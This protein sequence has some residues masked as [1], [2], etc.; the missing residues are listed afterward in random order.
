LR[1]WAAKIPVETL[2]V[3]HSHGKLYFAD[4]KS[5]RGP[6]VIIHAIC[7]HGKE[8]RFDIDVEGTIVEDDE[9]KRFFRM[10]RARYLLEGMPPSLRE[11]H[12]EH[13]AE[14]MK[15]KLDSVLGEYRNSS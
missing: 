11:F 4:E 7:S 6:F 14:I 10:E 13:Y 8:H 12:K 15:A 5:F 3:L 2:K 1:I 9:G